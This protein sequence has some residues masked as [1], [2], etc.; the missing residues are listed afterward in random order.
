MKSKILF[1]VAM[2]CIIGSS[3][4]QDFKPSGKVKGAIFG[5][6]YYVAGADTLVKNEKYSN[7]AF[8][9]KNA[10][11]NK[12]RE[13]NGFLLR[14]ANFGYEYKFAPKA[15]AYVALE[16]DE[17]TLSANNKDLAFVKDAYVKW[18]FMKNTDLVVGRQGSFMFEN[19]EKNWGF[20]FIE[21]TIMDLRGIEPSRDN[22][23]SIRGK[24]LEGNKLFYAAMLGNSSGVGSETEKHKRGYAHV[25]YKITDSVEVVAFFDYA[26]KPYATK[27]NASKTR[28]SKDE[29]V[30]GL[31]AGVRKAQFA[32]GV[33]GFYK[34]TN[35]SDFKVWNTSTS[36]NDTANTATVGISVFGSYNFTKKTSA[37]LRYDFFDPNIRAMAVHD[38]RHYFIA[39]AS[40][41]PIKDIYFSPNILVE[42]YEKNWETLPGTPVTQG[43][44]NYKPS[45]WPRLTFFCKF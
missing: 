11:L 10:A 6:Y 33:E 34:I 24:L 5:D 2:I 14:R 22:G 40:F 31:Y 4:A 17:S 18:E 3:H 29:I 23:V 38:F 37:F 15:M 8:V 30:T 1:F 44:R 43:T 25:G 26:H 36:K 39:G 16:T 32:F 35:N 19:A 28:Y 42:A 20:R 7:S 45:I 13:A 21:K 9:T 27:S 41:N 12:A